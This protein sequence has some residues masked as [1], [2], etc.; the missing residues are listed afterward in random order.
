MEDLWKEIPTATFED[1]DKPLNAESD[2]R[3]VL[4]EYEDAYQYQK[5][6]GTLIKVESDDDKKLKELSVCIMI[7]A[8]C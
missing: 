3:D 8:C 7:V 5:V 6:F 1:I 4:T 2:L